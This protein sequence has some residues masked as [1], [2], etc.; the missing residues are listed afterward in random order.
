M[1][2]SLSLST[3]TPSIAFPFISLR[4]IVFKGKCRGGGGGGGKDSQWSFNQ[5]ILFLY[6]QHVLYR[7]FTSI[8]FLYK[9][10]GTQL[11]YIISGMGVGLLYGILRAHRFE[12]YLFDQLKF[13]YDK[14]SYPGRPPAEM[15]LM[16]AFMSLWLFSVRD[17]IQ[18]SP[19]AFHQ[20]KKRH[21]IPLQK[22]TLRVE[23]M[24][25]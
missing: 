23:T 24:Y 21:F 25:N 12:F 9:S 22:L 19:S 8:K 11:P 20:L 18:H 6:I 15:L 3:L 4:F 16:K 7:A 1:A 2:E 5:L 17:T 13:N 14:I 10:L